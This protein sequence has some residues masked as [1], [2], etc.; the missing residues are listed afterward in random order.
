MLNFQYTFAL[1]PL[2]LFL[3]QAHTHDTQTSRLCT[4]SNTVGGDTHHGSSQTANTERR[5]NH[6]HHPAV[7]VDARCSIVRHCAGVEHVH[8][9]CH[10]LHHSAC[11]F[12]L[13]DIDNNHLAS[14]PTS[15]C[16]VHSRVC[17]GLNVMAECDTQQPDSLSGHGSHV[18]GSVGS[19]PPVDRAWDQPFE[20]A[21]GTASGHNMVVFT[22]IK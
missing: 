1:L 19:T 16:T 13:G 2:P 8:G 6:L 14:V 15:A 12:R 5:R 7:F 20:A 21:M 22:L 10:P 3:S 9:Q 17:F 11:F 18:P 4:Q